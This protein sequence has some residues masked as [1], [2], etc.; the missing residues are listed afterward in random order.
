MYLSNSSV[1]HPF[2]ITRIQSRFFFFLFLGLGWD[3]VCLVRQ[4]LFGQLYQPRMIDNAECETVDGTRI[5]RG[6]RSTRRKHAITNPTWLDLGSNPGCQVRS[7]LLTAW[8][9]ARPIQSRYY[10]LRKTNHVLTC[11][12]FLPRVPKNSEGPGVLSIER[13]HKHIY[14][15][16]AI[17]V[18]SQNVDRKEGSGNCLST[19]SSDPPGVTI[20][21]FA[22]PS[23]SCEVN[24]GHF[25]AILKITTQ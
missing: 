25:Y 20:L 7:R 17:G 16:P 3:W 4:P 23:M 13:R 8:A 10:Q 11:C 24:E 21:S 5:G 14:V 19:R 15:D 22:W 6:N 9:M 18:N 12:Y 1:N 2:N